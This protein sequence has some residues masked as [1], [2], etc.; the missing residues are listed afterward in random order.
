MIVCSAERILRFGDGRPAAFAAAIWIGEVSDSR[1][2]APWPGL[3]ISG[4]LE[5]SRA[6]PWLGHDQ[7]PE[8]RDLA[9]RSLVI[10]CVLDQDPAMQR[11]SAR[12]A[13]RGPRLVLLSE[14]IRI[15]RGGFESPAG[16]ESTSQLSNRSTCEGTK[17]CCK[18]P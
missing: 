16:A 14:Q 1:A 10:R 7:I 11:T 5:A 3:R 15:V 9:P 4:D 2:P 8:I 18:P 12:S 6:V 17:F 13:G